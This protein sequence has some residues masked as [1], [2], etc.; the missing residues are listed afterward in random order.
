MGWYPPQSPL[1][2]EVTYHIFSVENHMVH[3]PL[4]PPSL[5]WRVTSV[6]SPRLAAWSLPS[7]VYSLPT[8]YTEVRREWESSC[9]G[10]GGGFLEFRLLRLV[11]S[12]NPSSNCLT[13]SEEDNLLV[14]P[15]RAGLTEL[16]RKP[17]LRAIWL[18]YKITANEWDSQLAI[19]PGGRGLGVQL[20]A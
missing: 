15:G 12:P 4:L 1:Q 13:S 6:W 16:I 5:S 11:C 18:A 19:Q 3:I 20:L 14:F 10:I 8:S 9:L 17:P 7:N 2:P